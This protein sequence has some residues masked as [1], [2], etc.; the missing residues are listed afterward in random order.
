[1][2]MWLQKLKY[3]FYLT[4]CSEG[5]DRFTTQGSTA[6][7]RLPPELQLTSHDFES[8]TALMLVVEALHHLSGEP[9]AYQSSYL[10][11]VVQIILRL[12]Q[13]VAFLIV[14]AMVEEVV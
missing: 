9:S 12:H 11:A 1:M 5:L 6:H 10:V 4:I 8:D 3:A 13:V 14:E 7:F 2:Q